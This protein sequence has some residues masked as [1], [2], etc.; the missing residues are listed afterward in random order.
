MPHEKF[1]FAYETGPLSYLVSTRKALRILLAHKIKDPR[2]QRLLAQWICSLLVLIGA[3]ACG[4]LL[5][6]S[7]WAAS[8]LAPGVCLL[9]LFV[10]VGAGDLVLQLAL[11]DERFFE[12]AT[13]NRALFVFVDDEESLPQPN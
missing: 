6:P 8:G 10:S 4:F 9:A 13:R 5:V 7:L 11:E 3:T 1:V 12:M 2:F